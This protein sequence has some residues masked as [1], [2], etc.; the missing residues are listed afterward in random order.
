MRLNRSRSVPAAR[1]FA[2][3]NAR[4][5]VANTV[6]H[7]REWISSA[8]ALNLRP[9]VSHGASA[10]GPTSAPSGTLAPRMSGGSSVDRC[11]ILSETCAGLVDNEGRDAPNAER[12]APSRRGAYPPNAFSFSFSFAA[13]FG[14]L[15]L[16]VASRRVETVDAAFVAIE[17]VAFF[18]SDAGIKPVRVVL[19]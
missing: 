11:P 8:R 4:R 18:R 13:V 3:S 6:A 17:W 14:V 5:F 9:H 15:R 16:G 2:T 1:C 19:G 10:D 7:E 12:S